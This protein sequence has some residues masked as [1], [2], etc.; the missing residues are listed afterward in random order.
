MEG[1]EPGVDGGASSNDLG[2]RIFQNT[3]P[4]VPQGSW[5]NQP[6]EGQAGKQNSPGWGRRGVRGWQGN[7][8]GPVATVY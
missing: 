8:G 5:K 6:R 2:L 1:E 7:V 4:L 3:V